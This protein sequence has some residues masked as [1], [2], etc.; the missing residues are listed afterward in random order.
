MTNNFYGPPDLEQASFGVRTAEYNHDPNFL[1]H[2][3]CYN[4]SVVGYNELPLHSVQGCPLHVT[5]EDFVQPLGGTAAWQSHYDQMPLVNYDTALH[6]AQ[7]LGV[8]DSISTQSILTSM[9]GLDIGGY[10]PHPSYVVPPPVAVAASPLGIS[11]QTY[12]PSCGQSPTAM[13]VDA[14]NAPT[15]IEFGL[16]SPEE[17]S[18]RAVEDL[19][20]QPTK[21]STKKTKWEKC[22]VGEGMYQ[23]PIC[24]V[25]IATAVSLDRHVRKIDHGGQGDHCRICWKRLA[26][27]DGARRHERLVHKYSAKHDH[28]EE[29]LLKCR[30]EWMAW[31]GLNDSNVGTKM[32]KNYHGEKSKKPKKSKKSK[33]PKK[34]SVSSTQ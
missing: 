26:R 22:K 28:F 6:H 20:P 27:L 31:E 2:D 9:Q 14:F 17:T 34:A 24:G 12:P 29:L 32:I 21:S 4:S 23:C 15:P 1:H 25:I 8:G 33:K 30:R 3:Y 13:P 10:Q 7:G 11:V 18:T 19:I 5:R 16:S